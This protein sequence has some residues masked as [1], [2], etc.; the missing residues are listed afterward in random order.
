MGVRC[1][2]GWEPKTLDKVALVG[3]FV[4]LF[5]GGVRVRGSRARLDLY[6]IKTL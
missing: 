3:I 5:V 6:G 4:Q 1:W 2:C